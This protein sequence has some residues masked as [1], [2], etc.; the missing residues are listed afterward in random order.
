MRANTIRRCL[1]DTGS[2]TRMSRTRTRTGFGS[3]D[4]AMGEAECAT[5]QN[6]HCASSAGLEWW[7][8]AMPYADDT[9]SS[10]HSNAICF[11]T[12]RMKLTHQNSE[13]ESTPKLGQLQPCIS[14]SN[15][16]DP[17]SHG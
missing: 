11:T 9:V 7:C 12:D 2:P 17:N 15:T 1:A 13:I 10:R 3:V 8:A 5:T 16:Q 14:R 6:A 4:L